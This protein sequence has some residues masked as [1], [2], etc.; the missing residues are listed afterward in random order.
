M[1]ATPAPGPGP[2]RD[3]AVTLDVDAST[4]RVDRRRN[5]LR[6]FV[7]L[8]VAVILYWLAVMIAAVVLGLVLALRLLLESGEVATSLDELKFLGIG[9]AGVAGVAAV[10]GSLVA[11]FRLPLQRRRLEK[12]VLAESGARIVG[13]TA[14]EPGVR[15][16]RN[17]LDALA[18]AADIPPPRFA[19]V[20]DPAPNSFA[21][22][23]RPSRAIV[24]VTRGA[25]DALARDELE[26]IL[27]YEVSRIGSA[28]V[29][30]SSWTVALTGAAMGALDD[31]VSRLV[32]KLPFW[33]SG[34]LRRWAMRDAAFERDKA[35]VR[36][37]RNPSSLL[38]ALETLR[39]EPLEVERVSAATAPLWFEVPARV[40]GART[41]VDERIAALRRLG[42]G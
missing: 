2:D 14:T 42:A 9:L 16:V 41:T 6:L 34:R 30:L 10:I 23:T 39:E 32:G 33:A 5:R 28:D 29:A 18:I 3:A 17:I 15:R 31:D 35:A 37:T 38:H 40:E 11:A 4:L 8:V 20:E 26:A 24:A 27:A 36:F 25:I 12:Q 19:I 7:T 13:D 21:V 22:G 1:T